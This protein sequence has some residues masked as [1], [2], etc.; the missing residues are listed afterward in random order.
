MA[1]DILEAF[2]SEP[3]QLDFIWPGFLC[4]TVGALVAPG[5]T[6]KSF[7][8]IQAAMGVASQLADDALLGLGTVKRGGAL[9]IAAEDPAA[10]IESRLHH[11]GAHLSQE[12][13]EE[14]AAIMRIEVLTGAR[15]DIFNDKDAHLERLKDACHGA[16]IVVIDTLSRIHHA[17]ENSNGA[18]SDLMQ[19]LEYVAK[20]S[21]AGVLFLHHTSK[22]AS[23]G[24]MGD[25]QHASRGAGVLTDNARYAAAL[26]RMD[27]KE[28]EAY[29]VDEARRG[30]FVRFATTKNNYGTPLPDQWLQK[31]E[32]GVLLPTKLEMQPKKQKEKGGRRDDI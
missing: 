17:D 16:R 12:A 24:N 31:H 5:A 22:A 18:M 25:H 1:I 9:Y 4:G 21:G 29:G 13:R 19:R 28:A 26:V 8:A 20:E 14:V 11:M 6:G 2:Q 27:D 10:I 23:F 32:G 15:F 30:Y 3:P 7:W